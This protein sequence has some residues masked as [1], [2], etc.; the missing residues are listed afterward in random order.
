MKKAIS[1]VFVLAFCLLLCACV[2]QNATPTTTLHVH[3]WETA[4]CT[5]AK[6][7]SICKQTE[8]SAI[9]H[10]WEIATCST[11]KT[12]TYCNI[13]EGSVASHNYKDGTCTMCSAKDPKAEQISNATAAYTMLQLA[14]GYCDL[15]SSMISDAWYFAIYKGDDYYN[16][17]DAISA[18]SS[19]VGIEKSLVAQGVDSYLD[20]LGY[21][22]ISYLRAAI[23]ATNSGALY[24]LDYA[25][26]N[27]D[28]FTNAK[29]CMDEA[30]EY[31]K[32][33]D[34]SYASIN[35]YAELSAYYSAVTSYYN[36]CISPSGSYSQLSAT[37]SGFRSNCSTNRNLCS[38]F[39]E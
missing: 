13:T 21:E 37:L 33:L 25:L 3:V 16:G 9:G 24:V 23:L 26:S 12:C 17:D 22:H 29:E 34:S 35:A 32:A 30:K 4:T 18:F 20:K 6:T 10:N 19:Y 36:F 11:P 2:E 27:N 39:F 8:G 7:C 38:L 1:L 31:I 28:G 14:E 5:T 15:F